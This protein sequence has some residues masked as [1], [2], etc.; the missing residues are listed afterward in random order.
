MPTWHGQSGE[1]RSRSESQLP[2][3]YAKPACVL[4]NGD[5]AQKPGDYRHFAELI[6]PLRDAKI[7]THLTLENHD[8]RETFYEV[9]N[10]RQHKS[11]SVESR[12]ISVVKTRQA[13]F[14]LLD[15]LQKTMVTQGTIGPQPR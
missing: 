7:D 4:V 14:S 6:G 8:H 15:S 10:A 1:D 3:R 11:L 2:Q 12:R 5:L 9:M 13:N